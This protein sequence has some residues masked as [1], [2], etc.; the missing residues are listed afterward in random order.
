[1]KAVGSVTRTTRA[2]KG[3]ITAPAMDLFAA[4]GVVANAVVGFGFMGTLFGCVEELSKT[5]P[6]LASSLAEAGAYWADSLSEE[7]RQ[8]QNAI[9]ESMEGDAA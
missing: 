4:N 5:H 3:A 8:G 1:M 9:E 6:E 7:M 2:P